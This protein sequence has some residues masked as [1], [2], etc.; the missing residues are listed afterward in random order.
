MKVEL[1]EGISTMEVPGETNSAIPGTRTSISSITWANGLSKE[2]PS[3]PMQG[4]ATGRVKKEMLKPRT[5]IMMCPA[6]LL[7]MTSEMASETIKPYPI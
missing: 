7:S 1:A 4:I 5:G 6:R 3:G 2:V